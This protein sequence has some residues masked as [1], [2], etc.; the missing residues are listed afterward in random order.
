MTKAGATYYLG[1]DQVGT[2][3]AVADASGSVVRSIGYDA[4]G[5]IL[6]ETNPDFAVPFGFAGGLHDRD[7]GL[8]RFG[9]RD[10]DPETGRWTAKDP[11]LFAGGDIDLYGYC[12]YDPINMTDP[13]GLKTV[14][15]Y[16]SSVAQIIA[17]AGTFV[18]GFVMVAGATTTAPVIGGGMLLWVGYVTVFDALIDLAVYDDGLGPLELMGSVCEE[19]RIAGK[20]LDTGFDAY[21]TATGPGVVVR[22]ANSILLYNDYKSWEQ[23]F[24]SGGTE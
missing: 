13:A 9:H 21:G 22:T 2:L 12:L 20:I 4:F 8:V 19:G 16:I 17:G 14:Q 7:T 24:S 10:Y 3:K 6:N 1:Y 18:G 11:I 5:N 23:E 15:Q